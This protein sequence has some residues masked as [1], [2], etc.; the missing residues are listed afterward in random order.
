MAEHGFV[1]H[2]VFGLNPLAVSTL[3]LVLTYAVII[4]DRFNRAVVALLGA[5]ILI[6]VGALDQ[7]EA[8]KGI[9]WNT[10][11]LLTGMMILVSIARRSGMFQFVAIWSAQR[12]NANPAGILLLLQIVTAV[13]SAL[14][15]NVTTVLLIV[16]VTLAITDELDVPAYPF[17]F[18][19]IFASN[20]GGA[21][22]LIGDPPNIL[23]GSGAGL[24][25]NAFLVVLGPVIVVVMLVQ[26]LIIH[27]TWGRKLHASPQARML[28]MGMHAAGTITDWTLMRQ[29]LVVFA[30]VML[31]FVLAR[32]LHLEPATIALGGAALLLL[33]HTW[34]GSSEQQTEAVHNSLAEVEWITIFFFVGL[35]ILVH[36]VEVSGLLGLIA[37]ALVSATGGH[38]PAAAYAILW[39][40]AL[41]SAIIDNIP[42]VATMMPVVKGMAPAFGGPDKIEPLWWS[43]SLGACLGGDATLVGSS[44]NLLV[45][46]LGER[47]GVPFRF[48]SYSLYALPMTIVSIAICH[49]YLWWRFF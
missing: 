39:G 7:V 43:L 11:G 2:I 30:L 40:S 38:L 6:L 24:D 13:L 4:W 3:I 10:I 48:V 21:S 18:A 14:L 17:L 45:A 23:I 46:G 9:D 5:A 42:F 1:P 29:S 34:R 28:V 49:V 15:D 12:V 20:I 31:A 36:A 47:N 44:A 41:L 26:L 16:S 27:V 32:W 22:T 19:E 37:D 35:F 25:F 33:L 8:V